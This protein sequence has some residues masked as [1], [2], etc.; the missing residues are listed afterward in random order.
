MRMMMMRRTRTISCRTFR[1]GCTAPHPLGPAVGD[2][3]HGEE[4]YVFLHG[5]A[6]CFSTEPR[7][8]LAA[9]SILRSRRAEA[10]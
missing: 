7:Q 8:H 5:S 4:M 6:T 1:F 2:S 9:T 10:L 3:W